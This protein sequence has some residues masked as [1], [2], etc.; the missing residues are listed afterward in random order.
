[1][2]LKSFLF[3]LLINF[4]NLIN[5]LIDSSILKRYFK[6]IQSFLN[7]A[8]LHFKNDFTS[9]KMGEFLDS[10]NLRSF[11]NKHKGRRCFV[12]GNGPSLSKLDLDLLKD[13]IVIGS[14]GLYKLFKDYSFRPDYLVFQDLLT[15]A[16]K[17]DEINRIKGI[18][19]LI[20]LQSSHLVRKDEDTLFFYL[21][22]HLG[23]HEI[24]P[25]NKNICPEYLPQFSNN[26]SAYASNLG[27]VTHTALQ[28]AYFLGCDPIYI[29]G[30]DHSHGDLCK[31]F[32]PGH[33]KITKE[34]FHI[35]QQN[36]FTKNY[37][38]IGDYIGVPLYNFESKGYETAANFLNINNRKLFNAGLDSRIDCIEKV[39][40]T[41]LFK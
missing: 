16:K 25:D 6:A 8:N 33:V 29:I 40:F 24:S 28:L 14:N 1:M 5:P 38:K 3:T 18:K 30:C 11:F 15:I 17:T 31:Y 23:W 19:K 37:Y 7:Y 12:L 13:E 20:A 36:H 4:K 27:N 10:N 9:Q 39:P 32:S 34:N 2:Y 35:F 22:D 26:F 21:A 41:S